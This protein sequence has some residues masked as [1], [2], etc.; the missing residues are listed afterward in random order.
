MVKTSIEKQT[1]N[2]KAPVRLW[3]KSKFLGFRRNRK[4]QTQ[5]QALMKI[6]GVNTAAETEYYLG[7]RVVYIYKASTAKQGS[8]FR[9]IWG[10]ICKA[11]GKQG[12]VIARFK[13]NLPAKAM[14]SLLRVQLYP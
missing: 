2:N 4:N 14:G 5:N 7:K 8:K 3:V 11:H 10:K 6:E 12:V 13:P 1:H 9:T